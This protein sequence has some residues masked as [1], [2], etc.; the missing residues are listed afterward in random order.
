MSVPVSGAI[1]LYSAAVLTAAAL[2][3]DAR[4][5]EIPN[6]LIVGLALLWVLA[7][8]LVP[9][10]SNAS[11]WAALLCGS[12]ALAGGYLFHRAGWLGGGDGKLM[13]ALALWVGPW[14]LGWWLLGT[15]FLGLAMVLL[16]LARPNGDFGVRGIPFAWAI[17]PPAAVLLVARANS[18]VGV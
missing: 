12:G 6:W 13:G 14:E 16:A 9:Q 15:A 2:Y 4:L 3:T 17:A 10:V 7:I 18:L 1:S 5:R 8:W 11:V